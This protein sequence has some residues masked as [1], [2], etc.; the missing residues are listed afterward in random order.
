LAG[1]SCEGFGGFATARGDFAVEK[2]E[3]M[4]ALFAAG[5]VGE[6]ALRGGVELSGA[7]AEGLGME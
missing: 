6:I 1:L 2:D 5:E 7:D 4:L 3:G